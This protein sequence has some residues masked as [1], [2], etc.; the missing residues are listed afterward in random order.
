MSYE[1][2]KNKL[3]ATSS[4]K[5]APVNV[6]R[7]ILRPLTSQ[8]EVED[9]GSFSVS[10]ELWSQE[11]LPEAV[12]TE[13][14]TTLSPYSSPKAAPVKNRRR[15]VLKD[16]TIQ[17]QVVSDNKGTS[18]SAALKKA[19]PIKRKRANKKE[20]NLQEQDATYQKL[21]VP[22]EPASNGTPL[23][24]KRRTHSKGSSQE[25]VETDDQ[26]SAFTDSSPMPTP[27]KK[28]GRPK[29]IVNPEQCQ[30]TKKT[31]QTYKKAS[32]STKATPVKRKQSSVTT[33]LDQVSSQ[34]DE[35]K[36]RIRYLSGIY[37]LSKSTIISPW[38]LLHK[39]WILYSRCY[40]F[41][42]FRTA[43][44][45]FG[46]VNNPL[47]PS[48]WIKT[49]CREDDDDDEPAIL[50]DDDQDDDDMSGNPMMS[51]AGDLEVSQ[52]E[53]QYGD[54]SDELNVS[55]ASDKSTTGT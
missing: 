16:I 42:I 47:N 36:K 39:P 3:F 27:V 50:I 41:C 54:V 9:P 53:S 21:T 48:G 45:L 55:V 22:T 49:R 40:F 7:P 10:S 29:K 25:Q 35:R 4:P 23:K 20:K 2:F 8:E 11:N 24:R 1:Q 34:S 15:E 28:R 14:K 43:G 19:A 33:A 32:V 5:S 13:F 38:L 52:E 51:A 6:R 12:D 46:P 44:A 26:G 31:T 30:T 18:N 37:F 17:E